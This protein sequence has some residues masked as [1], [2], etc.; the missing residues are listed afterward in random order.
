MIFFVVRDFL[1]ILFVEDLAHN[2]VVD[3]AVVK[4]AVF[5]CTL[6]DSM[7]CKFLIRVCLIFFFLFKLFVLNSVPQE[8]V[9]QE[10]LISFKVHLVIKLANTLEV[11]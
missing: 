11:D 1:G 8:V 5:G 10:T 7:D 9:N 4:L 3:A 6:V 2:L